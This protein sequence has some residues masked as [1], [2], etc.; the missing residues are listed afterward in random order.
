[1]NVFRSPLIAPHKDH[2]SAHDNT[3]LNS[4]SS[5]HFF[6]QSRAN[7][8]IV[9]DTPIPRLALPDVNTQSLLLNFIKPTPTAGTAVLNMAA[10]LEMGQNLLWTGYETAKATPLPILLSLLVTTVASAVA[11]VRSSRPQNSIKNIRLTQ[12]YRYMPLFSSS[13]LHRAHRFLQKK[14]I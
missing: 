1:V 4:N 8:Q 12:N 6:N 2:D 7:V 14:C 10:L 5:V 9:D 13:H 11:F 3:L